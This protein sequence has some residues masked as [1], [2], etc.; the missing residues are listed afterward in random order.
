MANGALI[1]VSSEYLDYANV[2]LFYFKIA[3]PEN[4]GINEHDIELVKNKQP[5]YEPIYSLKLVELKTL[6]TY[7]KIYLK[8][9]FI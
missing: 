2:F 6:K 7:I 8:T 5:F 1:E 3:L 4:I 9:E